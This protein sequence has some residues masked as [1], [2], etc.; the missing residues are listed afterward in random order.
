MLD[1][2]LRGAFHVV[3]PAFPLMC[4]A[5]YGRIV[6]TSSIN[7]LYGNRNVVNYCVGQGGHHR[8]VQCRR[9][10]RRR[11]GR[12]VQCHPSRRRDAHGGGAGHERLSA[13]GP[14]AGGAGGGLAGA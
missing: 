11:G 7:G 6:L 9:A 8:P 12:E 1:V 10:R 4:K 14:G 5:G 13:D 3:R 2:H